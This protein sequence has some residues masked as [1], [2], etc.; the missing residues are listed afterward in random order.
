ME[1]ASRLTHVQ[2]TSTFLEVAP[3]LIQH[4]VASFKVLHPL[5]MPFHVSICITP[6]T[7][8]LFYFIEKPHKPSRLQTIRTGPHPTLWPPLLIC[9]L[10]YGRI[11]PQWLFLFDIDICN[12]S[13]SPGSFLLPFKES[14][15]K[16]KTTMQTNKSLPQ[17][18]NPSSDNHVAGTSSAKFK[19]CSKLPHQDKWYFHII[20]ENRK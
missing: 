14:L 17:L 11:L 7:T 10:S 12:L 19:E 6:H 2:C 4:K 5:H 1:L 8:L 18:L 20:F 3:S 15:I 16:C 9:C 13:L